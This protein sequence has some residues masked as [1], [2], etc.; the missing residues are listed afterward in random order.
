DH[1]AYLLDVFR[2]VGGS[3]QARLMHST[4]ARLTTCGLTLRS[5]EDELFLATWR[6]AVMRNYQIDPSP[7]PTWQV[8][9]QIE[10]RYGYLP[11]GAD[12][13]LRCT[14]FTTGAQAMIAEAWVSVGG[15]NSD[16]EAWIPCLI[17]RRVSASTPLAS[18]FVAVIEPYAVQPKIATLRRLTFGDDTHVVVEARLSDGRRDV[19]VVTDPLAEDHSALPDA[20]GSMCGFRF[21]GDLCV[22]RFDLEDCPTPLVVEDGR[23]EFESTNRQSLIVDA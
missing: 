11:A 7:A 15:F 9:W 17:T 19:L 13:H 1:D 14:D 5:L 22:V 20:I 2:V 16:E 6:N 21:D 4:F 23:L 12:I 18:T 10:D 8:D 3:E